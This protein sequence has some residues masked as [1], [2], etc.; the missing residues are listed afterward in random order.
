MAFFRSDKRQREGRLAQYR[1]R[2]DSRASLE[3][4]VIP[5]EALFLGPEEAVVQQTLGE[6]LDLTLED[7]EGTEAATD[8]QT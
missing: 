7:I 8:R 6:E 2:R 5:N 3:Q 4:R 1:Q